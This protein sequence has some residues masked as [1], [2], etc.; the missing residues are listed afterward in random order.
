MSE[1]SQIKG[2]IYDIQGFSVHDG[3]G[4]RTTVFLKGCP[5]HCPWC[6]SPESQ[7]FLTQM[8]YTATRC[9]GTELCGECLR[10][11]PAQAVEQGKEEVNPADKSVLHKAV[12]HRD[13]CLQCAACTQVCFPEALSLCGKDYTVD[14]VADILRADYAYFS[15]S[16][17][18]VTVSGGEPLSQID[19]TEA[20]LKVVHGEGVHTAVDTTGFVPQEAIRRVLPYTDLFL[21]DLKHMDSAEHE[22]ITGVPNELIHENARFIARNGGKM[23]IRVPVIPT[24]NDSEENIRRVAEFCVELGDAVTVVQ[25]LPFH[26][27]GSAKY[28]R[29][30]MYDPIPMTLE[31]PSDETMERYRALMESY[32][33]PA[34]I[35]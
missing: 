4:I 30:Q 11:C 18:G 29:M 26:H 20:L 6:H 13:R 33:L 1:Q 28:E 27:F 25:L 5:L 16:D 32:G 9:I 34:I 35:H 12:W 7:S 21:Y 15:G 17:G 19:F 10:V 24:Y 22:R 14:E 23:Q 8:S 31:S 2:K 3:P